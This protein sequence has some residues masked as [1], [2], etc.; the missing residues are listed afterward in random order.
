M[1]TNFTTEPGVEPKARENDETTNTNLESAPGVDV[2]KAR[3]NVQTEG[4]LIFKAWP[5]TGE[6]VNG[7]E[8][9][10]TDRT[11][12]F[13]HHD[14]KT[15]LAAGVRRLKLTNLPATS[16]IKS[17]LALVWGG[18]VEALE[19]VPGNQY[20]FVRFMT[21]EDCKVYFDA[22]AN[23]IPY[24]GPEKRVIWVET[25]PQGVMSINERLDYLIKEK[26]TRI[27]RAVGVDADWGATGLYKVAS[28]NKRLVE[29]I[30]DGQNVAGVSAFQGQC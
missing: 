19:Y 9:S 22:S 21:P 11:Y 6:R 26:A 18:P 2:A 17:I 7:G 15:F 4:Q 13:F 24:P 25:D 16:T 1:S 30:I 12:K 23:G 10:D 29:D 8:T 14:L 5:K 27:V 28:F 3:D 20:A